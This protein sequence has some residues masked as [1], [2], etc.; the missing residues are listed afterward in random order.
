MRALWVSEHPLWRTGYTNCI[1]CQG[2]TNFIDCQGYTI[3]IDCQGYTN[4]IDCQEYTK[5]NTHIEC[6]GQWTYYL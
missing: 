2:Y 1:D 4:C 5:C 3:C 6:Q